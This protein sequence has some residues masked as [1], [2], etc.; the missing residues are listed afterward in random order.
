MKQ[1]RT[2][3]L[4]LLGE[5][6]ISLNQLISVYTKH[7]N[8]VCEYGFINQ[9]KNQTNLHNIFYRKMRET[10]FPSQLCISV[11]NKS[12]ETIKSALT[13]KK[14]NPN[15]KVPQSKLCSIRYDQRSSTFNLKNN[16]VSLLTQ[17]G[18]IWFD[19]K[20][21]NLNYLL[22]DYKTKSSE[23]IKEGKNWYLCLVFEKEVE[24][25]KLYIDNQNVVGVDRGI[26]NVAVS[27]N[28]QFYKIDSNIKNK[29]IKTERLRSKLQSKGTESARRHLRKLSH[30]IH[31]YRTEQNHIISKKIVENTS[32]NSVL[33]LEDLK[34][35]WKKK[36]KKLNKKIFSWNFK[37]LE[38]FLTYKALSKS[39]SVKFVDAKYTSQ[40]CSK[41]RDTRKENR[42]N[43]RFKCLN[44]KYELNADLNASYNIRENWFLGKSQ[45][46]G[47]CINQP[48]VSGVK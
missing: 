1:I 15:T 45:E 10:L 24:D 17:S 5:K 30:K 46:P 39:I 26:N 13:W 12:T 7:Y 23:L 44:C 36:G 2:I 8:K 16:K 34:N 37:Q 14:K 21:R 6:L 4:K 33:V 29:I 43:S 38:T 19:F 47:L 20:S 3:K 18:R 35:R 48:I 27:S 31:C 28:K 11:L 41:C 40:K 25:I 9:E 22:K 42:N 32:P